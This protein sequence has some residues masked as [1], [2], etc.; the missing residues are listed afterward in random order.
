MTTMKFRAKLASAAIAAPPTTDAAVNRV[1]GAERMR[2][3]LAV[4]D[5]QRFIL[6]GAATLTAVS[7][8]T[9]TRFTFRVRA[10]YDGDAFDYGAPV[11]FVSILTGPDNEA[12]YQFLGTIFEG[13]RYVHGRRSTISADAPSARAFAYVWRAVSR[14]LEAPELELWH[15]GRCA[16]CGRTLTVPA[17]IATGFGPDCAAQL[18]I[19]MTDVAPEPAQAALPLAPEPK[20]ATRKGNGR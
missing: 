10:P 7:R 2:G 5:A 15:E 8:R 4:A 14:N 6:A 3:Q 17:S 13:A 18:G 20:R 9:G 11:R 12:H 19:P 16:R 1:E